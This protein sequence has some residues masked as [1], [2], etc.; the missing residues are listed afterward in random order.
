MRILREHRT[1]RRCVLLV[2][3][4]AAVGLT[5]AAEPADGLHNA[6]L[7]ELGA[8][9][10]GSGAPFNKDWPPNNALSRRGRGTIFGGPLKGGRV[11][12]RLVMPVEVRAVEVTG[13]DYHG[14]MQPKAIDIFV[15]N[16][17]V[18]HAELPETPGKPVRVELG[19]TVTGQVVGILVTADYPIRTLPNGKKGPHWGG[20]R[21]LAVLS[22]T[23][24][25]AMMK[26]VDQ[27][28]V[29]VDAN[30]IAPTAGAAA[31]GKV[32]VVGRPRKTAGHPCTI[33]DA[34][35][36]AHYK[37]MLKASPEL[38]A[39]Y[40]GLRKAMDTRIGQPLGIPQPA[41][42]P[43]G[44]WMHL[45]DAKRIGKTTYGAIHNQLALDIANLGAVYVLSGEAKY[46]EF[47]KRLLMAYADVY[48]HYG[49]GARPGFNHD[50]SKVFDQ[51]LGDATWLIQVARG[52]DLIQDL[53]SITPPERTHIADDLIRAAG[54]HI[55]GNHAVMEAQTNWSAIC[56][57]AVLMAGY[58]ADDPQLVQTAMYGIRGTA[59]KPTGGLF[60]RHFGPGAIDADGM[61]AEGA[62]GYQFMAL[63]ALICDA[64]VLWHHGIDMYRYRDCALKR[65]FDS[66]L[67]MA[68]PDLTTPAIHDSGHGSIV[69]RESFLYEFAYRRYRDPA[70][71]LIL[72]Q[73]NMRLAAQFQQ[74]PVS[75][76]Y[77]RDPAAK[78]APVE[79]KS[80]NFFGVGYGILRLTDPA[81]T[82]SLLMDYGPN[83]SHGHP[84]KLNVDLYAFGDRLIPDPGSVWYEQPA[85]RRWYHT[86]LAHNTLCV[87]ELEQRPCGAQQI[88]YGPAETFGIQRARTNEAY[89]GVMMDRSL[90]LTPQYMADVF[91]AF[92][93]LPRKMDLCWHVRGEL[94]SELAAKPIELP[95][96]VE[97]GYNELTDLRGAKTAG[98]WSA[99]IRRDGHA[100]RF[101]AAG[102]TP[103][104]VMFANGLLGM[105]KPPTI[106]ERRAGGSTVYGNAVDISD[107]KDGYVKSVA[108]SGG[109][110][111]G[112]SLMKVATA[113]GQDLCLTAWRPGTHRAAGLETD[114]RQ[115]MV[116][117]DGDKPRAMYLGG[118]TALKLGS[119]ELRRSQL[120]LAFVETAETGAIV[121]GNPSPAPATITLAWPGLADLEAHA[122]DPAGRRTGPA[123]V[124][125]NGGAVTLTLAPASR[126]EI[127]AK[128]AASVFEHRQALLRKRQAEQEA[129]LAKARADCQA[130]TDARRK[131]AAARP[132]PAGTVL[133]VQG[134]DFSAQGGGKVVVTDKKRAAVG[135]CFYRW[136][137]IGQ[138][139]EWTDDA[140]ADGFY[141][142]SICYCSQLDKGRR[143][144]KI[145]GRVQEPFAP[146][147]FPSTGGWANGSDDWRLL[148]APNPVSG[149]PLLVELR[150]GRNVLRLT[151]TN[152][153][154]VN[155][156]YLAVTS[157]DVKPTRDLLAAKAGEEGSGQ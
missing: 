41:R 22:P 125:A 76:L 110:A 56:T 124:R 6:A 96:P 75:I 133:V 154:G 70:Y 129:A 67:R 8:T 19:R 90:F 87:D 82:T 53:P 115:A 54:R 106:L 23:D 146:M 145:N 102:G 122:L 107:T 89:S 91:G 42:G 61:W 44:K 94:A 35:D 3:L 4:V 108:L 16:T 45:S 5:V 15:D 93:R 112:W 77:D 143:K 132:V 97:N 92:T 50:P 31:E 100:A 157:P 32:E 18:K 10:K 47:A 28:D 128:G 74:F 48:D 156:D 40:A 103:T 84:D 83:R 105:E 29:P 9:A 150:R 137:N 131:A 59:E 111:D 14:T 79:W 98:A 34:Q 152:G 13:L 7:L 99:T 27:Y 17:K 60:D 38:Q 69:G 20:W 135:K 118:G 121:V 86:T 123:A 24:V 151:N 126:A 144:L 36:I 78:T 109:L 139:I 88:V 130:R 52:Y 43:D 21:R 71:L 33:W 57:C 148:T 12:I 140:P 72:N 147:V 39:Q 119:V 37:A 149:K 104:E 134:E 25:A 113:A 64:E 62:M 65:L 30:A 80:V 141:N 138:W 1:L 117:R 2:T 68:Y 153:R 26:D 81:G 155:V 136:D 51:R 101:L 73:A 114:A 85:Y 46:A 116:L 127:A 142:L 55:V 11:D 63:E 120:G 58:A 95:R 66:P 49:I